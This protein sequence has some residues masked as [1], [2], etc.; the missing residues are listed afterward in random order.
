[1]KRIKFLVRLGIVL[2]LT[3]LVVTGARAAVE[4]DTKFE[5]EGNISFDHVGSFDWWDNGGTGQPAY[6]PAVLIA[7]PHS[8]SATDCSIFQPAGKFDQPQNWSVQAGSVG[9]S[10]NEL[11]NIFAYP[12]LPGDLG[13]SDPWLIM[14]MERTKKSGSF[15]LDFEFNQAG[16]VIGNTCAGT[17]VGGPT[18]TPGDVAVGFELK[19]NPVDPQK[20]LQVLIVQF[21]GPSGPAPM[22]CDASLFNPNNQTGT[23]GLGSGAC[24]VYSSDGYFYR[25]LDNAAILSSSGLGTATMNATAFTQNPFSPGGGSDT[26]QSYDANGNK[27]TT[28]GPFEFAEAAINL[29]SLGIAPHCPGFGSV[30]A[31]SRSSL[32]VGSDL[33]DLAG[34]RSFPVRC[35][36]EGHKY[37]DVNGNGDRDAGEQGLQGWGINLFNADTNQLVA[38]TVTDSTGYYRFDNLKDGNYRVEET[39]SN[40][41]TGWVQTEPVPTSGCGSGVHKFTI[42]IN[43]RTGIGDFG[44]GLPDI[45]ITKTCTANVFVGDNIAYQITVTNVGNVNLSNVG[46]SDTLLGSVASGLSLTP[47]ASKTFKPTYLAKTAGTVP[48]TATATGNYTSAT[49]TDSADCAS[50]VHELTVTKI[51]A[52]SFTRTYEW[53]IKKSVDKP[54]PISLPPGGSVDLK[55]TVEVNVVNVTDSDFAVTGTITVSNPA[56]MDAVLASVS[57]VVSPNINATV[58]CPSLIVP[59]KSSLMCTYTSPLPDAAARTNTATATLINNNGQTT[60]FISNP[61]AVSFANAMISYIDEEVAVNDS[62]AGFLGTANALTDTLPKQFTYTRTVSVDS[63]FC[64]DLQVDNTATFTTNDRGR[65]GSASV[66]VKFHVPCNGCTPGFWQGGAGSKLWNVA[67][68]PDW[69]GVSPQPYTQSTLFNSFFNNGPTDPRLNG[70]T[71]L[72]L[73]G[74]GG[75]SDSARRAARDMVAAYLNESAFPGSFPATSLADLA[76]MWYAAV[77]GGDAALDAFHNLVGSWNSPTSGICPL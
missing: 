12:V 44:N 19:G 46:V 65:T 36:I 45:T 71:M 73:V 3:I 48:N 30:H 68:D 28:V 70:L 42:N 13:N 24:P 15:A 53:G 67:N 74:S 40:Q 37:L 26:Y 62:Y 11:T 29:K 66:S 51:A 6:P 69:T 1:M 55:Y 33:K 31:K 22:K 77:T 72:D 32:S 50:Q 57:D 43:N 39:C 23:I 8:K 58:K 64:G 21:V 56:P 49:V 60:N 16:W 7:D 47:G 59:A 20:D 14:G 17:S 2:A 61:V 54:G 10:Q 63:T 52:T 27:D 35:F 41:S 4:P 75:T 9:P 5:I 34:P 76:S 18:R 38:S 25:F